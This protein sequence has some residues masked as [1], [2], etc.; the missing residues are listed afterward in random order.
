MPRDERPKQ[1][2]VPYPLM[3]LEEI[4]ALPIENMAMPDS[5]LYLWTTHKFLPE[6]FEI[7]RNWGFE[8][9]CLMTWVKNVGFTPYS[10]MYTTEHVLFC[11]RGNLPLLKLGKRLDFTGKVREHSRKPDEFYELIKQVSPEPRI[12]YF[13]REKRDGFDQWGNETKK[14]I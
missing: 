12:D 5:H 11:R 8:Y 2:G 10:W 6:S 13:S 1:M 14:F 9:Q 3:S 4:K 7:S